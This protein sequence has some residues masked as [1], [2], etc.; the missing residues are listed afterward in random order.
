MN[1]I[2]QWDEKISPDSDSSLVNGKKGDGSCGLKKAMDLLAADTEEESEDEDGN[3][4]A[5]AGVSL[6][7]LCTVGAM[8][9]H[10]FGFLLVGRNARNPRS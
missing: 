6:A 2:K 7:S 8:K 3:E 5:N 4:H 9:Y 1:I 10:L